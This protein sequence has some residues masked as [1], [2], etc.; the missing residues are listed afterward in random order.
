MVSAST[1][2][3]GDL[4]PLRVGFKTRTLAVGLGVAL[5][6]L[7]GGGWLAAGEWWWFE[8]GDFE[9]GLFWLV[10]AG[11]GLYLLGVWVATV[12]ARLIAG[13]ALSAGPEGL[14]LYTLRT[15]LAWNEIESLQYWKGTAKASHFLSNL[16]RIASP[17]G[18]LYLTVRLTPQAFQRTAGRLNTL[19]LIVLMPSMRVNQASRKVF[20]ACWPLDLPAE[21]G[22]YP[23]AQVAK[24]HG[25]V[26][27]HDE[28]TTGLD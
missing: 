23:L 7:L 26:L 2:F 5:A 12:A 1:S 20:F 3:T 25:V 8:H 6:F 9:N 10:F 15:V 19:D 24:A 27:E 14:R 22:L 11:A 28:R 18:F 17:H 16:F 21:N 13:C 4:P